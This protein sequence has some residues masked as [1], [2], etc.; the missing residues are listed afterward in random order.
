MRRFLAILAVLAAVVALPFV[1]RPGR[2]AAPAAGDT[3]VIVTPHNEAIRHEFEEGFQKWYLARTGRVVHVDWRGIGGGG[4][5]V[6]F[7]Q[8]E[9]VGSFRNLWTGKMGRPWSAQVQAG[10]QDGRIPAGAP[11]AVR[12]A[13]ETFLSSDVGCGI[14]LFFGGGTYEFERQA[15]SGFIVDSG[16]LRRHPDWFLPAAIPG[17]RGGETYW[18][19]QGRWIGCVLSCYGILYNRDGLRRLGLS[20]PPATWE[21]LADPRLAGQVALADPTKSGSVA[22]AF[23]GIVQ[24]QIRRG[25]ENGLRLLQ[26]IGANARYFTDSAQ[27]IPIDVAD[28]DCAA[29]LCIDFY[30]RQQEEALRRRGDP[31]RLGFVTPVGGSVYSVDPIALMRGAPNRETAEAF[32]EYVVS[33]D[34]QKLWNFRPGVP[35]GPGQYALRRLPVRRDF[36]ARSEWDSLRS[37]PGVDPYADGD[38]FTYHPEWTGGLYRELAFIS[39]VLAED[40]HPELVRAWRAIQAARGP[41]R[42]RAL[43]VLQ[44]MSAV[45][46]DRA[47]GPIRR[48]LESKDLA[49]EVRMARDLAGGFRSQYARAEAI[50]EN[51]W[52]G[53]EKLR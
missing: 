1:L 35:G 28:G 16:I 37:D 34:G 42:D 26:A 31:G 39:R 46:Y 22:E 8:G 44:D 33:M 52:Q 43:A 40:A 24:Q 47:G 21:D 17:A 45:S 9:Y 5:I 48:A 38:A 49:D 10:F 14:D 53:V 29:G 2:P 32:I 51:R 15:R 20:R 50:A 6:R 18:D 7:L 41:A 36:Y 12:E 25:W 27:K 13:R 30:G 3:L 23:E 19:P 11:A 4:D